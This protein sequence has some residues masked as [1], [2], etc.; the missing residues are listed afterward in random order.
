MCIEKLCWS[1]PNSRQ[2]TLYR[3]CSFVSI[4]LI[5]HIIQNVCTFRIVHS[6]F[7]VRM[8]KMVFFFLYGNWKMA[9]WKVYTEL[10]LLWTCNS[11]VWTII[12]ELILLDYWIF[13]KCFHFKNDLVL[14]VKTWAHSFWGPQLLSHP[15]GE[16]KK[17]LH[18]VRA[19]SSPSIMWKWTLAFA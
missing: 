9:P 7:V 10:Q 3:L 4:V 19:S 8:F 1:E 11:L 18:Q 12:D 15:V 14:N 17:R 13:S 16:K 6:S 2:I 5:K